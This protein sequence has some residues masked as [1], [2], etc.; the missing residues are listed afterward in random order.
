MI[1]TKKTSY[2]YSGHYDLVSPDGVL[3]KIEMN[4]DGTAHGIVLIEDIS[5]AFT[6]FEI[7]PTLVLFNCKS[8]LA[9]LGLD[10]VGEEIYLDVSGKRA[11]IRVH[12]VPHGPIAKKLLPLIPQGAHLG[13]LFAADDRRRVQNPHYLSR[14]FGRTDQQGRP[15]LL[16]GGGTGSKE[17]SIEKIDG[18]VVAY[19]TLKEGR[20]EYKP[21]IEGFLPT[22]AEGLTRSLPIR[23]FLYFHQYLDESKPKTVTQDEILLVRSSPLH[24][25][26]VFG[27]V[28]DEH[29]PRGM[30]HTAANILQPDTQESGDIYEL[31]GQ[32][33]T[34]IFDLPLEFY[35]LEPHREHVF[36]SDRDQLQ[37]CLE[38]P[39]AIFKLFD[40]A[41]GSKEERAAVF[42]VKGSQLLSLESEDWIISTPIKQPFPGILHQERQA[43]M[44]EKYIKH[45]PSYPFLK[46][47]EEGLI[48][49]QGVL[50]CRHFPSPFM[51]RMLLSYHVQNLLK[52]IYFETPSQSYGD[53]FSQE[54]RAMLLDLVNFGIPVYWADKRTGKLLQYIQ[55]P[56]RSSGM[57]VPLN[58]ITE[59]QN[60][61]F[62]GIYGS[63]LK[64]DGSLDE[65]K[66]LL[67]GIKSL[68]PE[69]EHPLLNDTTSL[70]LVTGGGP[71]IMALG[72]K[73]AQEA[74]YLSCGNIVDFS[75]G[76]RGSL[77]EQHQNPYI[78]AK[79]TYRL[80]HLVERQAEFFLDFPIFMMGGIG[81]D[82]EYSLEEVRL[83]VGAR[84]HSPIVLF[85][86]PEY[87]KRKITS[88]FQ[89]NK[90]CGT[91]KGSEWVSNNFICIQTAEQGVRLFKDYFSNRL[92][93]GHGGKVH[94]EGFYEYG[95]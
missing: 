55:R 50:F 28:V 30:R 25:R 4:N 48:T 19:L 54:D 84:P 17:L 45:Q 82:F 40:E 79:M 56:G 3:T 18:R 13:K 41:P 68:K 85:G 46:A 8:V 7:D 26:T 1:M 37:E 60:A 59:F 78:D 89:L 58:K 69:V 35:T 29:L 94:E 72:N 16:L 71:G 22:I 63:N 36:F 91:I 11:E 5:P 62:F 76:D 24:V 20:V 80:D 61:T 70:A 74:G 88:R 75:K 27:H 43:L 95:A 83:K 93:I 47:I 23:Q 66:K 2:L 10:V 42:V 21:G 44:V 53:F 38:N 14:M 6:G 12:L 90:E 39:K 86:S 32:S 73:V 51:K 87:W 52:A 31:Y 92:E 65:L 64:E 49:S 33:E 15:L 9:Q 34:E 77:N 81:T 67:E 57:F